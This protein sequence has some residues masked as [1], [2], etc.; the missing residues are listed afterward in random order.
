M[1]A[2]RNLDGLIIAAGSRVCR[3]YSSQNCVLVM[4]FLKFLHNPHSLVE[5]PCFGISL[6]NRSEC[7]GFTDGVLYPFRECPCLFKLLGFCVFV[8][9]SCED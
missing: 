9:Y 1:Y 6:T 5:M 3:G 7:A 4:L 8:G 2:I